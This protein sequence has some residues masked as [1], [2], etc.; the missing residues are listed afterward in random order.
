MKVIAAPT[1]FTL[2]PIVSLY[3]DR[4]TTVRDSYG[5]GNMIGKKEVD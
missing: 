1:I 3:D 5:N 2:L 4:S